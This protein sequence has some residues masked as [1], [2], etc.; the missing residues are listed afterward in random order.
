[1]N[2]DKGGYHE[3]NAENKFDLDDFIDNQTLDNDINSK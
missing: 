3:V 1:M 2:Q